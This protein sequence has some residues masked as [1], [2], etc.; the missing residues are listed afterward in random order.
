MQF[1]CMPLKTFLKTPNLN[2]NTKTC[3]EK[4]NRPPP[5]E[6]QYSNILLYVM[7][8]IFSSGGYPRIWGLLGVFVPRSSV[9]GEATKRMLTANW[10][11]APRGAKTHIIYKM[12]STYK[13]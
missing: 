2:N 6:E 5:E 4:H 8:E 13:P 7:K 3:N 12:I 10:A 11:Q 1:V 9:G